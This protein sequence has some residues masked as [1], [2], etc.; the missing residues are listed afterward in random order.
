MKFL[1]DSM[2]GR[3]A[4]WLRIMGY[5]THYQSEYKL[6]E[7]YKLAQERIF[8]TKNKTL[9]SKLQGILLTSNHIEE[10]IKELNEKLKLTQKPYMWFSR[11]IICNTKLQSADPQLAQQFVPEYVY[12]ENKNNIK[13]CPS[14]K[15]FYWPGTHRQKMI[16]KLKELGF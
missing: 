4:K 11:C 7:L 15:R 5:D 13:F 1:L 16:K 3:L 12:V 6:H 14:C 9:S 8:I 2:L 10:Q